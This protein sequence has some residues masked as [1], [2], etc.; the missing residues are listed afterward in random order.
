MKSPG[1]HEYIQNVVCRPSRE[2]IHVQSGC[3][4][5]P[6]EAAGVDAVDAVPSP[7]RGAAGY[8]CTRPLLTLCAVSGI[9]G[10]PGDA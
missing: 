8:S 2:V 9:V 1:R 5:R 3:L 7:G 6:F 10:E 4:R